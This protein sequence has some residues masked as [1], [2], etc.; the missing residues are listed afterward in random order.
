MKTTLTAS[1]LLI[2]LLCS[3]SKPENWISGPQAKTVCMQFI[4]SS[5][6]TNQPSLIM[7]EVDGRYCTYRFMNGGVVVPG[8]VRV[9]RQT[10]SAEFGK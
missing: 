7:E 5:G 6:F 2:L 9:D 10:S 8:H 1:T 4:Y 3:C